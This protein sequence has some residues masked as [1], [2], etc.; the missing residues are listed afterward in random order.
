MSDAKFHCCPAAKLNAGAQK[1]YCYWDILRFDAMSVNF[2]SA[3]MVLG[4]PK[5][6]CSYRTFWTHR[7]W[8]HYNFCLHPLAPLLTPVCALVLRGGENTKT[9]FLHVHPLHSWRAG[10]EYRG[11]LVC[12]LWKWVFTCT[13][14][15]SFAPLCP[16]PCK[17]AVTHILTP[18]CA[19]APCMFIPC[20]HGGQIEG[21]WCILVMKVSPGGLGAIGCI[22]VSGHM[23]VSSHKDASEQRGKRRH[24]GASMYKGTNKHKG[25]SRYK[26]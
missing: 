15:Y 24:K 16:L 25:A 2:L 13:C 19:L 26:V 5:R 1:L 23:G 11:W 6:L 4:C 8:G 3:H 18:T 22:S 10:E 7:W 9:L 17:L 20:T 21:V 14:L 12:Y